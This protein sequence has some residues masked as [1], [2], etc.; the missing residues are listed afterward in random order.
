M[1]RDLATKAITTKPKTKKVAVSSATATRRRRI[2]TQNAIAKRAYEI[3]LARGEE[4]GHDV[5]DWVRAEAELAAK[6]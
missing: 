3:F 6:N 2:P 1:Q 4:H 5:E